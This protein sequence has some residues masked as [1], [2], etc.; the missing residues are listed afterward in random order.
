M[1]FRRALPKGYGSALAPTRAGLTWAQLYK[2][3]GRYVIILVRAWSATGAVWALRQV[4]N[5]LL[6]STRVLSLLQNMRQVCPKQFHIIGEE[7]F[8]ASRA[9]RKGSSRPRRN[10]LLEAPEAVVL[11]PQ[12]EHSY[13]NQ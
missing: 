11:Q 8:P 6:N 4:C 9:P 12:A 13:L 1:V 7:Y 5:K 2:D 10:L 3:W